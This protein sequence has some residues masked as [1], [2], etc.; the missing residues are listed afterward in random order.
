M[1]LRLFLRY[2]R[3][4]MYNIT[5]SANSANRELALA[6]GNH[7]GKPQ[8]DF[9]VPG[10]ILSLLYGEGEVDGRIILLPTSI[11]TTCHELF[12]HLSYDCCESENTS[13]NET[14]TT[15][16]KFVGIYTCNERASRTPWMVKNQRAKVST[17]RNT[18]KEWRVRKGR[19]RQ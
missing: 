2:V 19:K 3:E 4:T 15:I 18:G 14:H 10:M 12:G 17:V 11:P 5:I 7:P 8:R 16:S 13:N 1:F 9:H 6:S